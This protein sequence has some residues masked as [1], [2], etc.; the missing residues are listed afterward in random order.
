MRFARHAVRPGRGPALLATAALLAPAVLVAGEDAAA[1]TGGNAGNQA[2][3]LQQNAGR[4]TNAAC[5]QAQNFG[6]VHPPAPADPRP[7]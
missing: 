4:D 7:L 3:L 5:N 6:D 2:C 1:G